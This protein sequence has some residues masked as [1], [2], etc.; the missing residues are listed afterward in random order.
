MFEKG[1]K[2]CFGSGA[3]G[4]KQKLKELNVSLSFDFKTLS[5]E[6]KQLVAFL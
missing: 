6:S 3:K 4:G 5:Y 2:F 1:F